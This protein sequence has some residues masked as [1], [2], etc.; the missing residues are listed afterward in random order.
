MKR[1]ETTGKLNFILKVCICCTCKRYLVPVVHHQYLRQ[2]NN[3]GAATI[4]HSSPLYS[5]NAVVV[6]ILPV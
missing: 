1:C 2:S 4:C 3:T 6:C 5:S